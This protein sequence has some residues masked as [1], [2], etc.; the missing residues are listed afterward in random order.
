MF[1]AN[2]KVLLSISGVHDTAILPQIRDAKSIDLF[3]TDIQIYRSTP[4]FNFQLFNT[5]S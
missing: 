5:P 3:P 4:A 1:E 2:G